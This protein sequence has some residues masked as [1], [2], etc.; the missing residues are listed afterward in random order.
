[1]FFRIHTI[2]LYLGPLLSGTPMAPTQS[3]FTLRF[4]NALRSPLTILGVITLAAALW[5][6][7]YLSFDASLALP[8]VPYASHN[9]NSSTRVES[10]VYALASQTTPSGWRETT[11]PNGAHIHGFTVLDSI[12]LRNGT[13][14]VVTANRTSFPPRDRLLSRPV[15]LRAGADT[16]PTDEVS[17]RPLHCVLAFYFALAIAIHNS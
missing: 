1:M 3:R 17:L 14:Y 8:L 16:E 13:F 15:E 10:A 6:L 5:V 11:I 7:T 4:R 9:D 2:C 12:Y